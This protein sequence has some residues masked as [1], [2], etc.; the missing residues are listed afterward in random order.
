MRPHHRLNN[1]MRVH[2]RVRTIPR[3]VS[4]DPSQN[5]NPTARSLPSVSVTYRACAPRH[6]YT[7]TVVCGARRTRL[8]RCG[9]AC[10][11]RVEVVVRG[12]HCSLLA[13]ARCLAVCV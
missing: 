8:Q 13:V 12:A 10:S 2:W 11:E 1:I 3:G 5:P 6:C 7:T 9:A 4:Q